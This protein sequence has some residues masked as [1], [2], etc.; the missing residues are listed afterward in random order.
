[1][2]E[3]NIADDEKF[4]SL[5]VVENVGCCNRF[6]KAITNLFNDCLVNCED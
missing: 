6:S 4:L 1:M 3:L 5:L 2:N